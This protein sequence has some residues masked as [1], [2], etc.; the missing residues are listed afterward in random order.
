MA[1]EAET[2]GIGV[3]PLSPM[4]LDGRGEPGLVLGYSR[5]LE[6]QVDEAVAAL[7]ASLAASGCTGGA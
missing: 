3:I 1:A 7:A 2:R 6:T 5:L 4:A